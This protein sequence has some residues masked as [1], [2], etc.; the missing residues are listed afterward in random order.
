M[1][2]KYQDL[3]YI[4]RGYPT[5][6]FVKTY[7]FFISFNLVVVRVKKSLRKEGFLNLVLS[8]VLKDRIEGSKDPGF[9]SFFEDR[10]GSTI[11]FKSVDR[12]E[13]R[14]GKI[15]KISDPIMISDP[16][17]NYNEIL[18]LLRILLSINIYLVVRK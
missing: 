18:I 15:N 1:K 6:G 11:L 7:E 5:Y 17:S 8:R 16:F 3:Y 9:R 4:F 13:D 10:I 12:I 14:I 2:F